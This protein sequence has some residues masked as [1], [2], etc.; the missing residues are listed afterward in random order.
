MQVG[1]YFHTVPVIIGLLL[2]C[3][4]DVIGLPYLNGGSFHEYHSLNG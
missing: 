3:T 2:N 1:Y 4:G